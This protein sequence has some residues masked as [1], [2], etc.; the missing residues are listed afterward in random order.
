LLADLL[1][2]DSPPT[3]THFRVS[4]KPLPCLP[5]AQHVPIQPF[6][7][8]LCLAL[9]R[10]VQIT[11]TP[12]PPPIPISPPGLT[13]QII[14]PPQ[15]LLPQIICLLPPA[16]AQKPDAWDPTQSPTHPPC[17]FQQHVGSG[18]P[19]RLQRLAVMFIEIRRHSCRP[20]DTGLR[21]RWIGLGADQ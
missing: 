15:N 5:N 17:E 9:L 10:T 18:L 19:L 8:S 1:T 11:D 20:A 16:P 4:Q 12:R 14:H 6:P 3:H 2:Q 13:H 7:Q 21:T